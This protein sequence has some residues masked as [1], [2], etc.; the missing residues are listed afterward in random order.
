DAPTVETAIANQIATEDIE[1]SFTLPIDTF[2]DVDAGD[3]LTYTATLADGSELPDWLT[4]DTETR[5][6]GGTPVN[7][8]IGILSVR[9][10]A[11]DNDSESVSDTFELEVVNVNDTPTVKTAIANQIATEDEVFNFT[12]AEDTFNDVD[13]GDSLTYSATLSNGSELPNWLSFNADT[14]TFSGIPVNEDVGNLSIIVTATDQ[15]G[16]TIS[17]TFELTVE[18]V[19]DA[20][21]LETAIA[22]Q[23]AI[24]DS[25]FSF[26][27]P[28]N[29]FKD[30]D[31]RDVLTYTAT[32]ADGSE[33]PSWLSF[34][35]ETRTFNGTPVNEN[36]GTLSIKIT[37]TD[38]DGES[39]SNTFDL[40][41]I[42]INDTPTIENALVNQIATEDEAFSFTLAEKYL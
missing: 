18:N 35:A 36:V 14:R 20:P 21:I 42:N 13:A 23:T 34:N 16:E 6:F 12:L 3:N 37:A 17:N 31:I 27:F 2:N 30:V 39:V 25:G 8:N 11:T 26:T 9:V 1:F 10:T 40:E 22:N 7:E 29:T 38:N 4:F 32:L 41:A 5:T 33:L 19:N 15:S 28:E 24:E